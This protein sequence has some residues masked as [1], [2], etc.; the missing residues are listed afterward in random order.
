MNVQDFIH[1]YTPASEADAPT[2]LL[3]HGTGGN[4]NSMLALGSQFAPGAGILSPRGKIL[5]GTMPRFFRRKAE[6]VFD[7]E[8]LIFRTHELADWIERAI[9]AYNI[10]PESVIAVGYSNGANIAASTL[11]LRPETLKHAILL[12]PMLPLRPEQLP[13]LSGVNVLIETGLRDQM[14]PFSQAEVLAH[15][16]NGCNAAVTFQKQPTGHGLTEA[17]VLESRQWIQQ[18]A[19]DLADSS[20]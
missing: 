20:R 18:I 8:D 13:D 16:L 9:D 3:L 14:V 11:L 17:D 7:M 10:A 12:R 4:E 5:E 15:L 2:L 19:A 1:H 6:G